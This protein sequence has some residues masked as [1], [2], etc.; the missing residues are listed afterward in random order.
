MQTPYD[1]LLAREADGRRRDVSR[2]HLEAAP[3]KLD[4]LRAWPSPQIERSASAQ[5]Q[6][7][8][9]LP[10]IIIELW[11]EPG[12]GLDGLLLVAFLPAMKRRRLIC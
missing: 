10:K 12:H 6:L 5:P 2:R 3:R 1:S 8:E 4:R 9:R 7:I 11:V